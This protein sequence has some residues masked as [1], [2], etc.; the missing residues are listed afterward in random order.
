[1]KNSPKLKDEEREMI[2]RFE[3][4]RCVEKHWLSQTWSKVI[5]SC[6]R[7]GSQ[8]TLHLSLDTIL[9]GRCNANSR[10]HPPPPEHILLREESLHYMGRPGLQW[11]DHMTWQV[12]L[13]KLAWPTSPVLTSQFWIWGQKV[14]EC[15][16]T[17]TKHVNWHP[18]DPFFGGVHYQW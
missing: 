1:M 15:G 7:R 9:D 6:P 12:A 5:E 13:L 11:H 16:T 8:P 17:N 14:G 2:C 3:K 10:K 4:N 18:F